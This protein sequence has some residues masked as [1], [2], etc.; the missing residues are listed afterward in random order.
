MLLEFYL[1]Q[2]INVECLRLHYLLRSF[3]VVRTSTSVSCSSLALAGS[4]GVRVVLQVALGEVVV[5]EE[6]VLVEQ[7][8]EGRGEQQLGAQ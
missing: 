3:E 6:W 8:V 7:V 4:R 5:E 2:T 1:A